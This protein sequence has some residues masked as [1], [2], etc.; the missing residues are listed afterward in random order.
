MANE[1]IHDMQLSAITSYHIRRGISFASTNS[2]QYPEHL[3]LSSAAL[4]GPHTRY[5]HTLDNIITQPLSV[6]SWPWPFSGKPVAS[7]KT[8]FGRCFTSHAYTY[9]HNIYQCPLKQN[10]IQASIP[11]HTFEHGDM[12]SR[13][14]HSQVQSYI[15]KAYFRP[16]IDQHNNIHTDTRP[17]DIHLFNR[18]PRA[19]LRTTGDHNLTKH[20]Y[21]NLQLESLRHLH[22]NTLI[23]HV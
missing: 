14:P 4:L 18:P 15:T 23:F 19:S 22:Y 16:Q 11:E 6:K 1:R 8:F 7:H 9:L 13:G 20:F 2:V 17:K 12:Q 21:I 3:K 5:T 10:F